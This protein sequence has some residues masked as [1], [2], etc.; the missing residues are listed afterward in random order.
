MSVI[1][2]VGDFNAAAD[3]LIKGLIRDAFKELLET[4]HLY[5]YVKIPWE[6]MDRLVES[7]HAF[8]IRDHGA[9]KAGQLRAS[10]WAPR[11]RD[12]SNV[13]HFLQLPQ[14]DPR[15]QFE[16]PNV[17]MFCKICGS[18]QAFRPFD[19]ANSD[20]NRV[21]AFHPQDAAIANP[22]RKRN[23]HSQVFLLPYQC[24]SC[25]STPECFTVSRWG[26]KITL[27]GRSPIEEIQVN[28][29][30]PE[31][32]RKYISDAVLAYQ[33]GQILSGIFQ[34]RVFIE[35]FTRSLL[36]EGNPTADQL[37]DAYNEILPADF[38]DRFPSLKDLYGRL[39]NAIHV[40]R[41]DED[42]FNDVTAKLT[43]H[44]QARRVFKL[45]ASREAKSS[46]GTA[47]GSL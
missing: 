26:E 3:D 18:Q 25:Q 24:Q 34:L 27:V 31:A 11:T 35:Q 15:I 14:Q 13:N 33:C 42:L 20:I 9:T 2:S 40:A 22:I 47:K 29:C 1:N 46:L 44:F 10:D 19:F 38:K 36:P 8:V 37:L 43:E 12:G 5:Q 39:S 21:F 41:A 6:S 45:D 16:L 17:T 7:C 23:H 4:R 30:F 28:D 32:Q